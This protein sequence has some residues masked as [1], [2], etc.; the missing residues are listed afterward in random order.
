[1]ER[2]DKAS[3]GH[4]CGCVTK[5][6]NDELASRQNVSKL[7]MRSAPKFEIAKQVSD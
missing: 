6:V 3:L 1:M 4:W 7:S 5:N 2:W